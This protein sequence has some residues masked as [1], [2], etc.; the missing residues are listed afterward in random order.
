MPEMAEKMAAQ[1]YENAIDTPEEMDATVKSD[2]IKW[3][4]V[5]KSAGITPE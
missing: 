3:A 4:K 1:G 5:V 2:L